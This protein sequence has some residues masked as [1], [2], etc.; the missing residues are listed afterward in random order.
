M[1]TFIDRCAAGE[2]AEDDIDDFV[3]AWHES[4]DEEGLGAFLG[5]AENEYRLWLERADVLHFI[6]L[7]RRWHVPIRKAL[8]M[9]VESPEDGVLAR[10]LLAR[11]AA[12]R[13]R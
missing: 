6:L 4:P 2:L 5:M 12:S 8:E 13:A 9:R 10:E 11:L 1:G 7:A 3:D